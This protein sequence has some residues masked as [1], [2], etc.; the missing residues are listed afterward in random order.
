MLVH[1][2]GP[3]SIPK[4]KRTV[5]EKQ[6]YQGNSKQSRAMSAL[7]FFWGEPS[8]TQLLRASVH[9]AFRGPKTDFLRLKSILKKH[10]RDLEE[11]YTTIL[12]HFG[13][14]AK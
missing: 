11:F 1:L 7:L 2:F 14:A 5:G 4:N 9:Q 6:R 8:S 10:L 3:G 13:Y 12:T